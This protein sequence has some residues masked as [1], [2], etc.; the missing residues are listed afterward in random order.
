M[1]IRIIDISIHFNGL[2]ITPTIEAYIQSRVLKTTLEA[3]SFQKRRGI[4]EGYCKDGK[5]HKAVE[6]LG[7]ATIGTTEA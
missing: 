6:R 2:G 4:L 1:V 7:T 3:I 5:T